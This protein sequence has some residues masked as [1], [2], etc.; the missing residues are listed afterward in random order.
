MM[1][2]MTRTRLRLAAGI[3]A[4]VT[5]CALVFGALAAACSFSATGQ[6]GPSTPDPGGAAAGSAAPG[7]DGSAAED[8][9]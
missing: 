6:G 4:G 9:G 3:S 8:A 5:A 1:A 2:A 7:P